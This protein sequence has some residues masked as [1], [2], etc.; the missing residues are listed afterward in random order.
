MRW[1]IVAIS[2]DGTVNVIGPKEGKTYPNPEKAHE[3]ADAIERD[4]ET[5]YVQPIL[6]VTE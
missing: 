4:F 6:G 5:M 1:I 2:Y 3:D